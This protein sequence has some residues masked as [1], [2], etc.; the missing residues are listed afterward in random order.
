MICPSRFSSRTARRIVLLLLSALLSQP[1]PLSAGLPAVV[2]A[3][4]PTVVKIHGAGGF[5]GLEAYQSGIVISDT[6]HILTAWSYVLDSDRI[7]VTLSDG[8]RFDAHLL[9][10][11]PTLEVAVL[12]IEET[13]LPH[14][15]L[16]DAPPASLGTRVLAVAN[17][18]DV[19]AG[20]EPLSVLHGCVSAIGPLAARRGTHE[21]PYHGEVYLLDAISNNPGA[22]GGALIDFQG[23]LLGLIGKELRDARSGVWVNYAL[24]ISKL[25]PAVDAIRA[26]QR[27]PV[28]TAGL[29]EPEDPWT[30]DR[31]GLLLV[32]DLLPKTPAFV[33]RVRAE[34]VAEEGGLRADDLIVLAEGRLVA[35]CSQFRELVTSIERTNPIHVSVVRDQA[36][37]ELTIAAPERESR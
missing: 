12:T 1:A 26:G 9:G 4:Q 13:G 34:S 28:E 36:V 33:E 25:M 30:F 23:R 17:V 15:R 21:I 18:F 22:A 32:P 2:D 27:R 10:A 5:R 19:A 35:S 16:E 3:V 20:N 14:F 37:I 11:D 24:P 8:R 7:T 29:A 6:G 31:L